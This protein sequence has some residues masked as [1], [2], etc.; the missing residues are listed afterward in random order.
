MRQ[1]LQKRRKPS[2]NQ[3]GNKSKFMG[4]KLID[5]PKDYTFGKRKN[6]WPWIII[7]GVAA[8]ILILVGG[9]LMYGKSDGLLGA[10]KPKRI[11]ES[12]PRVL[13]GVVVESEKANL[14]PLCVMIE[15]HSSVRPQSGLSQAGVVYEALAEGG[16]TR[17][18]VIFSVNGE[19]EFGPVRSARPYFVDL[20]REYNC[21][22]VH[23]GGSPQG[24]EE[25]KNTAILDF[26]QFFKPYNFFRIPGLAYEHSLFSNLQKMQFG[27]EAMKIKDRG[28]YESWQFKED[29]PVVAPSQK[30]I[31]IDFSTSSYRVEYSYDKAQ[32]SYTR[33]QGG[34]VSIDKNNNAKI[35]P[36]NVAVMFTSSTLFDEL[37]RNITVVGEGK[38]II[39]EDGQAITGTWKKISPES[40]LQFLNSEG[41]VIKLNRG[42]TWV[43]VVDVPEK[44]IFY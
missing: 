24:L 18:L 8:V 22:Y 41:A 3:T 17:F 16:I 23:A 6:R 38:L 9:Y 29:S 20:A 12:L 5:S 36:K 19:M 13:D 7:G 44:N 43:E 34:V 30:S 33:S 37:R 26:D 27:R 2:P 25:I 31:K 32:N 42:H 1:Q 11:T 40:R 21:L 14:F 15:N 39:F 10:G 4:E 35:A 28:T